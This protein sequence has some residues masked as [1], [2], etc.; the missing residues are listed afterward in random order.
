MLITHVKT[1]ELWGKKVY[2][3]DGHYVGEVVAIA[4]RRGLARK[5]VVHLARNGHPVESV[6]RWTNFSRLTGSQT[7]TRGCPR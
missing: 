6:K 2:D 4:M 7:C 1:A 5:V 3:T